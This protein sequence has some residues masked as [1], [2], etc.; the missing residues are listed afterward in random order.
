MSTRSRLAVTL[1]S[2]FSA[3][4]KHASGI[5]TNALIQEL[6]E[7]LYGSGQ[8]E[9]ESD[10]LWW[11][12]S[13]SIIGPRN[14]GWMFEKEGQ[15]YASADGL[16]AFSNR[17]SAMDFF[18]T[19]G[20]K[21]W[22]GWVAS[23]VPS[24]II[25]V[26]RTSYQLK[27]EWRLIRRVGVRQLLKELF[28]TPTPWQ[29]QLPV[30]KPRTL[31]VHGLMALDSADIEAH[32]RECGAEFSSGGHTIYLPPESWS[33]T[34]FAPL[35]SLYPPNAGLKIL[36]NPGRIDQTGYVNES[37]H[38]ISRLHK[39]ITLDNGHLVLVS[40]LFH[41]NG[42][43]P[44]LV[45]LVELRLG[46]SYWV[47]NVVDNVSGRVPTNA[48]TETG[49]TKLRELE[50]QGVLR[51]SMPDGFADE[52]FRVPD[53]NGNAIVD[54]G[55]WKYVDHQNFLLTGYDKYL[56]QV[57]K[58]G[59][60]ESHYGDRSLL[61]GTQLYQSVPG[62]PLPGKRDPARRMDVLLRLMERA[63]VSVSGKL[64]LDIGCNVGMMIGQYLAHGAHWCHGWDTAVV[65]PKTEALLRAIGC[66]RFSLTG[67]DIVANP[68]PDSDVPP[69]LRPLLPGC[70]ISYL[71]VHRWIGWLPILGS[72]PW[73]FLIFEGHEND[74]KDYNYKS[75]ARFSE[76]AKFEVAQYDVVQDGD[77][78]S[79][80]M[81]ILMR[82]N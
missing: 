54:A 31:D 22:K 38:G 59:A 46:D 57:A 68:A 71:A 56:L 21:S 25:F 58:D 36:R 42:I 41:T 81:A 11:D 32:C 60:L 15:W 43:G 23:R 33:R 3:L 29:R 78:D 72:I 69:F 16:K 4:D 47:A 44:K 45:D 48:E 73:Q 50:S 35:Q 63:G 82:K 77:S 27:I 65:A 26:T 61:R 67:G 13:Y 74:S 66:T 53:C 28:G 80:A 76:F 17:D 49:L 10:R 19:A 64:V 5:E 20:S 34:A 39:L 8:T 7:S 52:D 51:V 75:F 2:V 70:A 55:G 24:L 62:V 79:R 14:A 6:R 18:V 30:Q 40:N 12:F 9:R 1:E 37:K